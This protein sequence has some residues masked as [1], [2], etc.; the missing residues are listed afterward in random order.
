MKAMIFAAGLGTRLR[1]LTDKTPKALIPVNGK[2]LLAYTLEKLDRFGFDE[3]IINVHYHAEQ[4]IDFILGWKST[5]QKL[6]ISDE[7][8][9]L[10]DTGGALKKASWFLKDA[11]QFLICNADIITGADLSRVM[12]DRQRT[13]ALAC[14]VVRERYSSRYLLFDNKGRLCGWKRDTSMEFRLVRRSS[15]TLETRAF[16]GIHAVSSRIFGMMPSEDAFSIIDLYL[17]VADKQEIY[18]WEDDSSYFWDVGTPAQLN[19]AT[20]WMKENYSA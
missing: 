19:A 20:I 2:P 4:V 5:G 10:L 17:Q 9:K 12:Y 13:D 16:S 14:L 18:G 1:P 11:G 15:S 8:E 7:R 3:I 6:V